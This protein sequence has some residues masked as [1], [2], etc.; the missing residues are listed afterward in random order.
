MICFELLHPL[1]KSTL[2]NKQEKIMQAIRQYTEIENGYL[3]LK[4]PEDFTEKNV[5]VIILPTEKRF[6][7]VARTDIK[8]SKKLYAHKVKIDDFVMPVRDAL[9]DR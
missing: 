8:P 5:E 1:L 9:Y 6:Q 7:E 2:N 4:L 3:H